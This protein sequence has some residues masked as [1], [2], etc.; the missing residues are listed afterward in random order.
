MVRFQ[1][2]VDSHWPAEWM[3]AVCEPPLYKLRN[4]NPLPNVISNASC[5]SRVKPDGDVAY[6]MVSRFPSEL[7]MQVDSLEREVQV[8]CLLR[9]TMAH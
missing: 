9:S 6:L 7:P 1:L 4:Y 8:V 3:D 5:R 2:A